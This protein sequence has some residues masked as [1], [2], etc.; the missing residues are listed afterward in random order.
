[1]YVY[2]YTIRIQREGIASKSS[3]EFHLKNIAAEDLS[4]IQPCFDTACGIIG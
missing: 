3:H 2:I 1:M 4:D